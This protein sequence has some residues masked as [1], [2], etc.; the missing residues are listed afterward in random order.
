MKPTD[1]FN[2][3][4]GSN[5]KGTRHT[6]PCWLS[7][8]YWPIYRCDSFVMPPIVDGQGSESEV[9]NPSSFINLCISHGFNPFIPS[10]LPPPDICIITHSFQALRQYMCSEATGVDNQNVLV[11]TL[12]AGG[13]GQNFHFL[14]TNNSTWIQH[15]LINKQ[16]FS[17]PQFF[18]KV[19][20][21]G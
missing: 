19:W 15:P 6:H 8:A 2:R 12:H 13:S 7:T 1:L 3:Q 21:R 9:D 17:G 16:F 4:E 20:E 5:S 14:V 18:A 10:P 11:T